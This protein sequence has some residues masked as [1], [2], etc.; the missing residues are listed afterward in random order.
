VFQA[1]SD[2]NGGVEDMQGPEASWKDAI[3]DAVQSFVKAVSDSSGQL[4]SAAESFASD[5]LKSIEDA[6][7][8]AQQAA[9]EA[10]T[11]ADGVTM[12]VSTIAEEAHNAI[13]Q[14]QQAAAQASEK[15]SLA[16]ASIEDASNSAIAAMNQSSAAATESIHTTVEAALARLREEARQ[17]TERLE[18]DIM[19]QAREAMEQMK[20]ASTSSTEM[21]PEAQA[22]LDQV[23]SAA[24]ESQ[25]ALQAAQQAA[26]EARTAAADSRANLERAQEAAT[27]PVTGASTQQVLERL[28]GDYDLLTRLVQ[29]LHTRVVNLTAP[30]SSPTTAQA[31]EPSWQSAPASLAEVAGEPEMPASAYDAMEPEPEPA[32]EPE[33]AWEPGLMH[34]PEP[35]HAE[36][37][38]AIQPPALEEMP[39][40]KVAG[41]VMVTIAPVPD[42]DRLLNL[43]GAL[44]RMRGIANVSLAD[45]AKEEVTFRLE[46]ES[47]MSADDFARSLSESAGSPA[48]VAGTEE[49]KIAL[50]LAS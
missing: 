15:A 23:R 29:E 9:T 30:A 47:P 1:D 12:T 49:G 28:E 42:F 13:E 8:R 50:R 44:G 17:I 7:E 39:Q 25:S 10:K 36:A 6:A 5:S 3:Q 41:R 38:M 48:S 21:P 35:A 14:A 45:Y 37:P 18:A 34:E 24:A 32:Y 16:V 33:P 46:V 43:D 27:A 4:A 20:A 22:M 2:Y 26:I 11:A 19:L 31:A 40:P